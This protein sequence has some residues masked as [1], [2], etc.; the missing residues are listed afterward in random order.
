M[1]VVYIVV[2]III[3][4]AGALFLDVNR[5]TKKVEEEEEKVDTK[6]EHNE[7]K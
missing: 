2:G 6:E 1:E 5:F 7:R 4:V 3:G